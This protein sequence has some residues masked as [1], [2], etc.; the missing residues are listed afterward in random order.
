M[1]HV[2]CNTGTGN[3][4]KL[5]LT[6][7][8]YMQYRKGKGVSYKRKLKCTIKTVK[9]ILIN[10]TYTVLQLKPTYLCTE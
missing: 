4:K 8:H 7:S 3:Y 6:K 2:L 10:N 1:S 9:Y 5:I